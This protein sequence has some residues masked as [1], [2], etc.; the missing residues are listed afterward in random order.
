M[1][2]VMQLNV[3]FKGTTC[4]IRGLTQWLLALTGVVPIQAPLD[5]RVIMRHKHDGLLRCRCQR[6]V[7]PL[8]QV[9]GAA[10]LK[11]FCNEN[12]SNFICLV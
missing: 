2:D 4:I 10:I 3:H 11:R 7:L 1:S 12:V 9:E 5:H 6:L 8:Q